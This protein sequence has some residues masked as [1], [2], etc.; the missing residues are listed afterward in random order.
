MQKLNYDYFNHIEIPTFVLSNVYHHHIGVMNNIDTESIQYNFNMNSKQEVS[1]DVYKELN[2]VKN[3]LWEKIIDLKYVYVPEHE[4]Y[5]VLAVGTDDGEY[6]VKHCTL[7]SAGEYE[8]S[9]K[10]IRSLEINTESDILRNVDDTTNPTYAPNVLCNFNDTDNS[11]LHRAIKD[12]AP[13]W[14]IA[15]CDATIAN[16]QRTFS[17]SNQKIYDFLTNTLAKEYDCLFKFNSVERTISC[18]D[19]LNICEDCGE[20]GEF[21]EECPVCKSKHI[22]YGYGKNTNIFITYNNFSEKIT[23][24]GD[25]GAVKNCFHVTGGDDYTNATIRNINPNGSEYIYNFSQE[26]YDDMPPDLVAG[27]EAYQAK[28]DELYDSYQEIVANWYDA[29]NN[30]YFYK[31]SMMPRSKGVL[32]EANHGYNVGDETYVKTLASW[33]YLKCIKTVNDS[34]SGSKE[35]DAT[36]VINGQIIQ[37]NNVTWQVNKHIISTSTSEQSYNDIVEYFQSNVI[38]FADRIPE[39]LTQVNNEVINISQLAINSLFR[40]DVI[41]DGNNK[42][43]GN[44]W[45]GRLKI[46]NSGNADDIYRAESALPIT[47]TIVGNI[48]DYVAYMED[49]VIKRL[50]RSDN[51]FTELYELDDD[52][53][54]KALLTQYGL[55]SLSSFS[56]SY[57]NC[58]DVLIANGIKDEDSKYMTW[59]VYTPIYLPTY[60]RKTWVDEEI[61]KREATVKKY[62]QLRDTYR[63]QMNNIQNQLDLTK[64]LGDD[65]LK[66]FFAYIRE[67]TYSNNNYISTGLS[68]G[69]VINNCKQ[70]LKVA[71]KELKKAS[72]LQITLTDTIKNL[73]NTE[74]FKRYKDKYNLGDYIF[75]E[76]DGDDWDEGDKNQ[77][78][79][80]LRL[81]SASYSFNSPGDINFTFSN[82]TK[83]KNFFS[84]AQSV[85]NSAQSI[86]GSYNAVVHQVQN[87]SDTTNTINSW[88][89]EG[90]ASSNT[91]LANNNNE[92]VSIG[93]FGIYAKEYDDVKDSY[94]DEQV[95]ITHNN[96]TFTADNWKTA[97][98][99]IGKSDYIYYNN[100]PNQGQIGWTTAEGYGVNARFVNSGYIYGGQIVGSEIYSTN[101]RVANPLQSITADGSYIN[102][103]DG[104]FTLAGGGLVG[105]KRSDGTYYLNYDGAVTG[106]L[107]VD[108]GSTIGAWTVYADG[109]YSGSSVVKPDVISVTGNIRAADYFVGTS[110]TTKLSTTLENMDMAIAAKMTDLTVNTESVVTDGVGSLTVTGDGGIDVQK[111][112]N[113]ITI[114][115]VS[116]NYSTTEQPIGTWVDG[117]VLYQ[118]TD[119][120]GWDVEEDET[121]IQ[122]IV[123]T[124]YDT[125]LYTKDEQ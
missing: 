125:I 59:D 39:S 44:T 2:G 7:T 27:L 104:S 74:E 117:K 40:V 14:T 110:T 54:F 83:V 11:I 15:H 123:Q 18:Y 55:D 70:L 13:D 56:K 91:I 22:H 94:S 73:L 118:K 124:G 114:I 119:V 100:D 58:L 24:D 17:V 48:Q 68:D 47:I 108:V 90:L 49:K 121:L 31:T 82:A 35:F 111:N 98:L 115:N 53:D 61:A 46:T 38:Y 37:D 30:Y 26:D 92:E 64:F 1:F 77:G 5:Y 78:L 107:D 120:T 102:F 41:A 96:I 50:N 3:E 52:N 103:D 105:Y 16:I 84:D 67:D 109:L 34:K 12:K 45:Y 25:E 43:V 80:R 88:V 86:S 113:T 29:M 57:Q 8:L 10:I 21:T 42:I 112:D 28:Y 122:R 4:E 76:C 65:L 97:A 99:A 106:H 32:W 19:L 85:I 72:E 60:N 6:T 51:T 116:N 66:T 71:E 87:N 62:E 20:R 69:E 75:V 63:E 9:N 89:T 33:A 93:E 23:R 79:Y 36:N 95:R 101:Y 81:I